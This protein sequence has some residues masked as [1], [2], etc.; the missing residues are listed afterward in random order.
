M[1]VDLIDVF[2]ELGTR[3]SLNF[4]DLLETTT[5]DESALG[6]EVLGKDLGELSAHVGEDVVGSELEEGF[7][8]GNV[9]AHL[10]DVLEGLL[11]LVLEVLGRLLEHVHGEETGRNVSLS[12][13]LGVLG[14][15][16]ANLSEGPGSSCL[17][18][19]FGLVH[20]GVLEGSNSLG[21]DNGHGKRVI[22]SRDVT[23]GHDT[24]ETGVSL[25]L[26]DVVNS[27]GGT[28]GMDDQLGEFGGLL[29]NLTDA[30]SG[31][32][33]DLH[34]DVLE[35]VEDTGEDLGLN[36]YLGEV[37]G[38]LGDL[39]E[40]L[41]DVTLKLGI[42]VGDEGSKVGD[43]TLVNNGLGKLFGMLGDLGQSGG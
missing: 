3:L 26:T 34:I 24:G 41:T 7:E 39:G 22:E 37:D 19:V 11:G 20:E 17:Q 10:D 40:A 1:R 32:L 27:G 18:V 31:V 5:L 4:L 14:G 2:A 36:D 38:V 9:G 23:E 43:G 12:E 13:V 28:T 16:T 35:A 42:G 15:V 30:S 8:G 33:T 25:G 21:N 6:L 29:G